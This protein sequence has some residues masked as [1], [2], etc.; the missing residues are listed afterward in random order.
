MKKDSSK[1]I[2]SLKKWLKERNRDLDYSL[3]Q[4]DKLIIMLA[5]GGLI[6]TVGFVK[7]IVKIT[8]TTDTSLLK[9]CWYLL[10]IALVSI[11]IA[12]ICSFQANKV[13]IKLT[14]EELDSYEDNDEFNETKKTKFIR[15]FFRLYNASVKIFNILSFMTL[16][17]G[18]ILFI[19]FVNQ[20]I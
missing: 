2:K 18:I 4:F 1:Y 16:V 11:L 17:I 10:T 20:N 12:Q 19:I 7:D 8:E 14:Q 13:E 9:S 6:F 5:S 3:E 15:K